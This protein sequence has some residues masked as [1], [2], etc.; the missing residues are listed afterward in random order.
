MDL[1]QSIRS[2]RARQRRK[3]PHIRGVFD[4]VCGIVKEYGLRGEFLNLL[5]KTEAPRSRQEM[6][7]TQAK[8][9]KLME[10]PP[11]SLVSEEE[12][13]L[14][15][16]IVGKLDNPYLQFAHSPEEILLSA[17]L[18]EANPLLTS[19]DLLRHDFETLLLCQYAKKELADL[20]RGLEALIKAGR[21]GE[22]MEVSG[23]D[24]SHPRSLRVRIKQLQTFISNV[25]S[26]GF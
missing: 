26:T 11:F 16:T 14:A 7:F 8:A 21:R 9:K 2:H 3:T 25:E 15:M 23:G 5:N 17:P 13:R 18:Y 20:E 4:A 19:A 1:L 22:E 12:F 10:F 6:D 24:G